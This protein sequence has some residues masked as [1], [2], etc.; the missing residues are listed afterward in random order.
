MDE[1]KRYLA[2]ILALCLCFA[3]A[4]CGG[5]TETA[6]P[7]ADNPGTE[8]PETEA[9][10]TEQPETPSAAATLEEYAVEIKSAALGED[11][12]GNPAI[13]ITFSWTNNSEETVMPM[14]AV[15]TRAFQG[16]VGL[17]SAIIVGNDNYDGDAYSTEVRP[18]T[19]IDVQ[20]AYALR[21]E[22]SP[23]EFEIEKFLGTDGSMAY[24]EFDITN[25]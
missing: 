21:D 11:Y 6:A 16:G 10:E 15:V 9:P 5:A 20:V 8:A 17:D 3:L 23:V 4:A 14:V 7:E 19:T 1:M 13:M 22:T 25:L 24:K 12:E 18:G 2:L